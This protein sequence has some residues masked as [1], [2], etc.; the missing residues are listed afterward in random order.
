MGYQ[1]PNELDFDRLVE[2]LASV[3]NRYRTSESDEDLDETV[4]SE[5]LDHQQPFLEA[6]RPDIFVIANLFH[7][8]PFLHEQN[9]SFDLGIPNSTYADVARYISP[10]TLKLSDTIDQKLV[11]CSFENRLKPFDFVYR[12]YFEVNCPN[13][14]LRRICRTVLLIASNS[15][16]Q[17]SH[18]LVYMN[19]ITEQVSSIRYPGYEIRFAPHLKH[20]ESDLLDALPKDLP[21]PYNLSDR[22]CQII[23][24]LHDGLSSKMIADH[25]DLSKH[26]VDT[27]RR[28]LLKKLK[29]SNTAGLLKAASDL[30][31]V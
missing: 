20:I 8:L 13:P 30:G 16:G 22:E 31:I 25:L 18:C 24:E 1:S 23:R 28:K 14:N 9:Y 27:Y 15:E 21:A 12:L 29:V 4:V 6:M 17:C 10:S 7:P 5:F 2:N 11:E 26:T 3:A 19:N